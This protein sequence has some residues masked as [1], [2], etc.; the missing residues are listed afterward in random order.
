[1]LSLSAVVESW[2]TCNEMVMACLGKLSHSSSD[3]LA[4]FWAAQ[5]HLFVWIDVFWLNLAI[6]CCTHVMLGSCWVDSQ[7]RPTEFR[8]SI[9][10][11]CKV[12]QLPMIEN[13]HVGNWYFIQVPLLCV[14]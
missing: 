6:K 10:L 2:K 13:G 5:P 11:N 14:R 8:I 4:H 1:L 3:C 7:P 12:L 9:V